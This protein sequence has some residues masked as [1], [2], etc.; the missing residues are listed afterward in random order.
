M[1][2][3]RDR[4]RQ[5]QA[6]AERVERLVAQAQAD[7]EDV[8][9]LCINDDGV[10]DVAHETTDNHRCVWFRQVELTSDLQG[11]LVCNSVRTK[12]R[13]LIHYL[14]NL[15]TPPRNPKDYP[16]PL[17]KQMCRIAWTAGLRSIH[18]RLKADIEKLE[19]K[20]KERLLPMPKAP[21]LY[22][23]ISGAI[24]V[25][26]CPPWEYAYVRSFVKEEGENAY[27]V[28]TT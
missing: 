9:V 7:H 6:A 16:L 14:F 1:P 24:Q 3:T 22:P 15:Y 8:V 26:P 4:T 23:D 27:A 20:T 28:D 11:R 18:K 21:P 10:V 17:L 19:G 12:N 2:P 13:I 5:V 25:W